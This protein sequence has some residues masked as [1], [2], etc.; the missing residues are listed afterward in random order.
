M[1]RV[2][3]L[4]LVCFPFLGERNNRTEWKKRRKKKRQIIQGH[5]SIR[6][7]SH[8][9]CH[10]RRRRQR[11]NRHPW[12]RNATKNKQTTATN[13][14]KEKWKKIK[15]K[16]QQKK[17]KIITKCVPRE[18]H[19]AAE[20]TFEYESLVSAKA[21]KIKWAIAV[22]VC[23]CAAC[24]QRSSMNMKRKKRNRTK[25]NNNNTGT[26][27]WSP[28]HCAVCNQYV[29]LV[30]FWA[31]HAPNTRLIAS[32]FITFYHFI[33]HTSLSMGC[34]IFCQFVQI[35]NRH[36]GIIDEWTNAMTGWPSHEQTKWFLLVC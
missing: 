3:C 1:H 25:H 20:Y 7:T 35:G 23:Q 16:N 18:F 13:T 17:K 19:L 28:C 8:R 33:E 34:A 15:C 32:I 6:L 21:K 4:S 10:R 31:E 2:W 22:L 12:N 11:R 14:I 24:R 29:S 26:E 36:Q 27:K 5:L 9:R 30:Y